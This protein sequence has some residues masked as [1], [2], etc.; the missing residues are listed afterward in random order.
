MAGQSRGDNVLGHEVG[1]WQRKEKHEAGP[2]VIKRL[3]KTVRSRGLGC[4]R[5]NSI[6]VNSA[7][8]VLSV[9]DSLRH[10]RSSED[11][12][13]MTPSSLSKLLAHAI[14][15]TILILLVT[16]TEPMFR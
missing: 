4:H 7:L 5:G 9:H 11:F 10:T 14:L 1:A 13:P 16:G 8:S 6:R 2:V 15:I 3:P 12:S